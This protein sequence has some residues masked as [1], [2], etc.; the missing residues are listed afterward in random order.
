MVNISCL[1]LIF[2]LHWLGLGHEP[3]QFERL[4]DMRQLHASGR[5]LPDRDECLHSEYVAVQI[6]VPVVAEE[7][8]GEETEILA[9]LS[10]R[11][12]VLKA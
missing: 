5:L 6:V 7:K 10:M 11:H 9:M 8:N 4:R 12:T 3:S 2:R 1:L